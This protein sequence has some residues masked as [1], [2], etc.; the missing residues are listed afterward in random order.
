MKINKFK[1]PVANHNLL[2]MYLSRIRIDRTVR[3]KMVKFERHISLTNGG[4][5]YQFKWLL[6]V[7]NTVCFKSL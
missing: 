4:I 7:G 6:N 2:R 3:E 5:M 1:D